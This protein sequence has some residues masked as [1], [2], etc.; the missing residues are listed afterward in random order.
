VGDFGVHALG[1]GRELALGAIHALRPY[2][3]SGTIT[4]VEAIEQAMQVVVD[5]CMGVRLPMNLLTC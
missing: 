1:V 2:V 3:V 5:N 4:P